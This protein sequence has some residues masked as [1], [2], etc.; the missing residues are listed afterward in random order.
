MKRL[1]CLFKGHQPVVAWYEDDK[2]I[3]TSS[4][5]VNCGTELKAPELKKTNE[6]S[7]EFKK[8]CNYLMK[9]HGT[10]K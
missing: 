4:V 7:A 1:K 6:T 2:G 10:K 9:I 5:C 8:A 3:H